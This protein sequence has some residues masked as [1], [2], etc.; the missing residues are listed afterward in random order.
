MPPLVPLFVGVCSACSASVTTQHPPAS[1]H[2]PNTPRHF[3][4]AVAA[5][6]Q[7][8]H[9]AVFASLSPAL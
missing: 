1:T 4:S 9:E 8:T 5:R 6:G 7:D 3:L 2:P